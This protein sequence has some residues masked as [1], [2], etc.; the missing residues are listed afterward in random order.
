MVVRKGSYERD[1][2]ATDVR[3]RAEENIKQT[4]GGGGGGG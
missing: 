1:G 4:K 3:K 2:R